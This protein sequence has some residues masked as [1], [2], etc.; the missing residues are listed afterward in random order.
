MAIQQAVAAAI[1]LPVVVERRWI[2]I[3][4]ARNP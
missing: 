3:V 2:G 1:V 4:V